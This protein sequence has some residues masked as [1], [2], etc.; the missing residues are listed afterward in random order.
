MMQL[1]WNQ[2]F[3]NKM[4]YLRVFC[5]DSCMYEMDM[6]LNIPCLTRLK[7]LKC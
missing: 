2:T 4:S 6:N 7:T 3:F 5:T 1:I